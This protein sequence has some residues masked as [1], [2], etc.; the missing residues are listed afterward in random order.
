VEAALQNNFDLLKARERVRRQ[1]GTVVELR[2]RLIPNL[3]LEGQ[4]SRTRHGAHKKQ[5]RWF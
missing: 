2:S 5:S 3:G 1:Y 4:Y